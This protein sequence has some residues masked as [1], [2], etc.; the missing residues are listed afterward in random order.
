MSA[1]QK[2]RDIAVGKVKH[3][4][5]M[6]QPIALHLGDLPVRNPVARAL[7]QRASTSA[8]GAHIRSRGAQRRAEK[9]AL[10]KAI[11]RGDE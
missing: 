6:K 3:L 10:Q 7:A 11:I 1:T 9:V 5:R 4:L 8:A 2:S